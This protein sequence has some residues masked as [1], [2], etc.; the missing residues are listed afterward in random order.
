MILGHSFLTQYNGAK[1]R[2]ISIAMSGHLKH[3]TKRDQEPR[4]WL[5]V[6][7]AYRRL[8]SAMTVCPACSIWVMDGQSL[9]NINPAIDKLAWKTAS[10]SKG[11]K[12]TGQSLKTSPLKALAFQQWRSGLIPNAIWGKGSYIDGIL[13]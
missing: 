5:R 8:L 6:Q 4:T 11:R 3:L 7:G 10:G 12:D 1:I 2:S 13:C 9:F